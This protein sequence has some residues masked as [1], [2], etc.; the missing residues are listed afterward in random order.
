MLTDRSNQL[1]LSES[2][3]ESLERA[4]QPYDRLGDDLPPRLLRYLVDGD[5]ETVVADVIRAMHQEMTQL[6]QN[7][8]GHPQR[9]AFFAFSLPSFMG[10]NDLE[11]EGSLSTWLS[12]HPLGDAKFYCR[13]SLVLF[14][15]FNSGIDPTGHV[16]LPALEKHLPLFLQMRSCNRPYG[17]ADQRPPSFLTADIADAMY[18][19]AGESPGTLARQ[20]YQVNPQDYQQQNFANHCVKIDGF[21]DYTLKCSDIVQSALRQP[22]RERRIHALTML[23]K[24]EVPV[25]P[26]LETIATSAV[27]SAKTEREVARILLRRDSQ[28]AIPILQAR[29][30]SGNASE[31]QHAIQLLWDLA[32]E[33]IQPFLEARLEVEKSA[34][35]RSIFEQLLATPS[36]AA[37]ARTA[38]SLPLLPEIEFNVP[39]PNDA[40]PLL[41]RMVIDFNTGRMQSRKSLLQ[42]LKKHHHPGTSHADVFRMNDFSQQTSNAIIQLLEEIKAN[43]HNPQLD[44]EE[45]LRQFSSI[46]D[47]NYGHSDITLPDLVEALQKGTYKDCCK[48][49]YVGGH[50]H[51]KNLK[52]EIQAFLASPDTSLIQAVRLLILMRYLSV[53]RLQRYSTLF[54]DEGHEL[55][56]LYRQHHPECGGLRELAAVLDVLQLIPSRIGIEILNA[57]EES[58]FW[59]WGS[60]AIWPYFAERLQLLENA[61][62]INAVGSCWDGNYYERQQQRRNA[63]KVLKTFPQPPAQLVSR[64]WKLA[65]EGPKAERSIVQDCL[66]A[67]D[68]SLNRILAALSD[69][70]REIRTIAAAWLGDR[71]D[72]T[73]VEPLR[74]VLKREKSD[75]VKDTMR[76]TLEKLGAPVE[77]ALNRDRLL[78]ESQAL[79]KQGLPPALNWFPWS[80]MPAVHWGDTGE[81]VAIDILKGLLLQCFKQKN[82]EPGPILR[83][84]AELWQ[85]AER[86]ALGQF[87][88]ESWIAQDTSPRY[89]PE[90]ADQIAQ[91]RAQQH[92]QYYQQYASQY[93]GSYVP[94][95]YEEYYRSEYNRLTRDCIGTANREKGMLAIAAACCGAGAVAPVRTYLKTWY[96]N[97]MAQCKSL[98]TVLAW[99]EDDGA[100]QLLL[101]VAGRFRTKG[102]QKEAEQLVAELAERK[103]WSRDELSDRTIP[104]AGFDEGAEQTLDYGSRQF[105]LLLAPDLSLVLKNLEGKVIKALP[106]ARKDDDPDQ[107]KAAR[108]QLSSAKKQIKQVLTLQHER[109]YEAMCTQRAW[110]FHD[111]DTYLN[112]HPIVGRYCQRLVWAL[113]DGDALVQTVRPL[114]DRTLTDPNDDD[115]TPDSQVTVRLAHACTIPA[116]A[117]A[118][119]QSHFADYD[120]TPLFPQFRS[121]AYALPD[122]QQQ[123]T[124]LANFEGYLLEAF[125]LRGFLSKRGYVRGQTEDAGWFYS[126][127]KRFAELGIDV[128]VGFSGNFLPEENRLVALTKVTFHQVPKQG[129][130]EYVYSRPNLPLGELPAVLLSEVWTEVQAIAALGSGYDP[131]WEKKVEY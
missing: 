98:L 83:R 42:N 119:W 1:N 116:A 3:L 81:P 86:E 16:R 65:F 118:A 95:T 45:S 60:D 130:P 31:R 89:T 43:L 56:R 96:G 104:T 121:S 30:E 101:S 13:A 38:P 28:A 52:S 11:G 51:V 99:T 131:N 57:W 17:Y 79:L 49:Q 124:E 8:L 105:T 54:N 115:V 71:G 122:D 97:R 113:Y 39:V 80:A 93:G 112:R 88:L 46:V 41:K 67:F 34:K 64:L 129:E 103:G 87:V 75:R 59:R 78:K 22:E 4:L 102:I 126:Y 68:E 109:L 15:F 19:E 21:A 107:V 27:S 91:Q 94:P 47:Q 6:Q 63:F 72:L 111:W 110:R 24:A 106:A 85:P 114:E 44:E 84:Y 18:Q 100:I 55:L 32:G 40:M 117:V 76:R 50:D 12:S 61:L 90:E 108:H 25:E 120:V 2:A 37:I 35:V 20:V 29:A 36:K 58:Q 33:E 10:M 92:I 23:I 48:F 9:N 125:K 127:Q 128:V 82:P 5:D 14:G 70:S 123:S 53:E 7:P 66:N 62:T 73:A 26:F 69:P 77:E 74:A